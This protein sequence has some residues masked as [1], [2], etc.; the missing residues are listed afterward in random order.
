VTEPTPSEPAD[1]HGLR[2]WG[3]DPGY[4]DVFGQWQHPDPDVARELRRVM[5]AF[6]DDPGERPPAGPEMLVARPAGGGPGSAP[7]V[8]DVDVTTLVGASG[9]GAV[10]ELENGSTVMLRPDERLPADVPLGYHRV[11]GDDGAAT[12]LIVSPGRCALPPDLHAW[13]LTVQLYAARSRAS[14]G[15][16]DLA[17]LRR[18][19]D[20]ATE[21]GA[22]AIGLNPLHAPTPAGPTVASPYTPSSRRWRNPLHLAVEEVPGASELADL[23]QLAAAGR[24]LNSGDRI[25]RDAVWALKREVLERLWR[26]F[27]GDPSFDAYRAGHGAPLATWATFCA[28]A[29]EHGSSWRSWP[30][31]LQR[32]GAASTRFAAERPWEIGFWSWLQWLIDQQLDASGAPAVAIGDLAVGID[33][34]GADAWEWQDL[35]AEGVTVGAPPDRFGPGGQDWGLPPFIPWKLR[36]AGYAPFAQ[37]IRAVLGH[38][39]GLRVDHVMGLFR[40]FWVPPERSPA[41]GAYVRWTGAELLD[42]VAL[43]S[44]RA[45][46]LVVGEDLGTVEPGVREVLRDAGV[47]STRLLWFEDE[48][49]RRWPVQA[50]AGVTTHDLPTVA[51]LWTGVDRTDQRAAGADDD[52]EGDA[53]LR[54][55]LI[56][57]TGAADD[58][59]VDDVVVAAHEALGASPAMLVTAALDDLVGA[60][61]RPNLPGT[62]DEHPNWRIPLP[63]P[64]DD[65]DGH[66]LAEAVAA[67]LGAERTSAPPAGP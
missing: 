23:D 67:T 62:I 48:P 49:P 21:R 11:V 24:A 59:P 30:A 45:G 19:I 64:I 20:W 26:S 63:V 14:W 5:G 34:N 2:A 41:D 27:P 37:T 52:P 4:E 47:L 39:H 13:G 38:A 66:P 7:T 50:M 1:P 18:I 40:L 42:V 9:Q 60:T 44:A 56:A 43:E 57:A 35:L 32:P 55:R 65:L 53:E 3:I 25:D 51:G 10:L 15:I 46:A 22:G 29:D 58:T 31:Q 12:H 36:A 6:S 8:G 33:P 16:G 54:S 17:D 28:L 61:H